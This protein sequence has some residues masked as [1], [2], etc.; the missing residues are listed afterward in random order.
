MIFITQL[1]HYM[2]VDF[3]VSTFERMGVRLNSVCRLRKYGY[4]CVCACERRRGEVSC[5]CVCVHVR[6]EGGRCHVIVCVCACERR[7]GRCDCVCIILL[8]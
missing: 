7:R 3:L 5:D 4:V 8:S 6:G 2:D 1:E